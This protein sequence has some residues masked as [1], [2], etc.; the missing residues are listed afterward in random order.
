MSS[1][2]EPEY[3]VSVLELAPVEKVSLIEKKD[4]SDSYFKPLRPLVIKDLAKSWPALEKWTPDFFR[5][6]H[7]NKQVKVYDDSFV[8]AGK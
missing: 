5:E 1:W 3:P 6:Q 2:P 4:F 8:A 7:G